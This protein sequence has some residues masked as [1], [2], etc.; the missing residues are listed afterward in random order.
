MPR[1]YR[2]SH[3]K[4]IAEANREGTHVQ[5]KRQ[6]HLRVFDTNHG[7]VKLENPNTPIKVA[8]IISA[9]PAHFE[10]RGLSCARHACWCCGLEIGALG[11]KGSISALEN[12]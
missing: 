4:G 3:S 5:V 11:A 7:V 12:T 2:A 9:L 6:G 8:V 1:I 10:A